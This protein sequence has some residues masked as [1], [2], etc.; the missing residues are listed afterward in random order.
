MPKICVSSI[1]K[2]PIDQVFKVIKNIEDFPNFMRDIKSLKIIKR[3]DDKI[4]TAW[5]IEI[6]GAPVCWKE[7]DCFDDA[8]YQMK[9][10]MVEGNYDEYQGR[11]LL[12]ADAN[13]T[14]LSIEAD[15]DW[16]I[17]ILEKYVGKA[18]EDKARRSLLGMAQAI[19]NKIEKSL[20]A[21]E[22]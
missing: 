18:L 4:I 2:S 21:N 8:N 22:R 7:E 16:G 1:I 9:F 6:D 20:N 17:P 11:W 19:K 14:K 10:S 3:L 5:E 12:Q 13:G 15:F